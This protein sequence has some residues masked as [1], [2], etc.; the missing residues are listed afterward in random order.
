MVGEWVVETGGEFHEV[1]SIC[2]PWYNI[3]SSPFSSNHP[4]T[5]HTRHMPPS[6]PVTPRTAQFLGLGR[7]P[8]PRAPGTGESDRD[9]LL[10]QD[11]GEGPSRARSVSLAQSIA[12]ITSFVSAASSTGFDFSRGHSRSAS[13]AA[14]SR[15]KS[16]AGRSDRSR[17]P[18][19]DLD[20]DSD[21]RASLVF[22]DLE[23][24]LDYNEDEDGAG[25]DEPLVRR[26]RRRGKYDDE[27][28]ESSLWEVS[29]NASVASYSNV[30]E[31]NG[32]SSL[33]SFSR[34]PSPSSRRSRLSRT[35]SCQ[36]A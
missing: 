2:T 29:A 23:E 20:S 1:I 26:S 30:E 5:H 12:S 6:P 21:P 15:P 35:I 11:R 9:A 19:E 7:G 17:S 25:S 14:P 3:A 18:S 10:A 22:S 28:G 31:A 32:S 33:H 34:T 8:A 13:G 24:D 27:P 16:P 4:N 36:P